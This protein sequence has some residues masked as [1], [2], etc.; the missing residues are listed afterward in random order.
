MY[1]YLIYIFI[2]VPI[3]DLWSQIQSRVGSGIVTGN[4]IETMS[5]Q[6]EILT[7]Y[8][9]SNVVRARKSS[10]YFFQF[11]LRAFALFIKLCN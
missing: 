7:S 11:C 9:R 10:H 4:W 3:L 8:P 5:N 2:P 1:F 6:S